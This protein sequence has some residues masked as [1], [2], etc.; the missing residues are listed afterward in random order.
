[1]V[2]IFSG[3]YVQTLCEIF[4]FLLHFESGVS[5][6]FGSTVHNSC[7]LTV[8]VPRTSLIIDN[9]KMWGSVTPV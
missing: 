4:D 1:M 8:G 2:A 6:V 9:E 5:S 3:L 7:R